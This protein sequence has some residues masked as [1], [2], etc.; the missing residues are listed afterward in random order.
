MLQ[1]LSSAAGVIGALRVSPGCTYKS[2]LSQNP[3]IC[4]IYCSSLRESFIENQKFSV[5]FVFNRLPL[6]LQHRACELA[7]ELSLGKMLFPTKDVISKNV[8]KLPELV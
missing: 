3:L 1:N 4:K 6:R 5:R 7:S 8:V 2:S